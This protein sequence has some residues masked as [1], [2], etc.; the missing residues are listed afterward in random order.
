MVTGACT[1]YHIDAANFLRPDCSGC[2]AICGGFASAAD[3]SIAIFNT[4]LE[5]D[6]TQSRIYRRFFE[7]PCLW[8]AKFTFQAS[9]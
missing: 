7:H 2:R 9:W 3:M 8:C 1:V 5:A 6:Q 4:V